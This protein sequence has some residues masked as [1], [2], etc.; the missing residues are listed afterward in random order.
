MTA[1]IITVY[2]QRTQPKIYEERSVQGQ[3][4]QIIAFNIVRVFLIEFILH[5][6]M[7]KICFINKNKI[8][9]NSGYISYTQGGGAFL[10]IYQILL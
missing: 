2:R 6:D 4:N 8:L 1:V 10:I 3:I 5:T 7:V 9:H